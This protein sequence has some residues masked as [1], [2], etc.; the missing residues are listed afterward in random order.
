M[1]THTRLVGVLGIAVLSAAI[2]AMAPL[3][4]ASNPTIPIQATCLPALDTWVEPVLLTGRDYDFGEGLLEGGEPTRCGALDWGLTGENTA[5]PADDNIAPR[6]SGRIFAKNAPHTIVRM[7][8]VY[9]DVHGDVLETV[10]GLR[11]EVGGADEVSFAIDELGDYSS[12]SIYSIDIELQQLINAERPDEYWDTK[13]STSVH[14]GSPSKAPDDV[15]LTARGQ[16]F[17]GP[18]FTGGQPTGSGTLRWDRSSGTLD[19]HLTGDLFLDNSPGTPTRVRMTFYTVHGYQLGSITTPTE[20]VGNSD[21]W[22]LPVDLSANESDYIYA[23]DVS[24]E[25]GRGI[26]TDTVAGPVRHTI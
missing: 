10:R 25:I 14:L 12:P 11:K 17:G 6:L 19:P 16:D 22:T 5:T 20:E 2:P 4:E 13:R 8:M 21:L 3:A 24:L 26:D 9:R 15:R 7:K 18:P 23:V 1:R